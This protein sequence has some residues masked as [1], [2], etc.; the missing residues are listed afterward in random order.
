MK[1]LLTP[2]ALFVLLLSL[3]GPY[4]PLLKAQADARTF[5]ETGHTVSG[6]FLA[7]WQ[8]HGGLAQ[9]GYPLSEEFAE[10]SPLNGQSYTVQYFERAVFE[11]HPENQPPFNILLSQLG[12]FRY[13]AKYPTGA[14]G[15]QA[16]SQNAQHFTQTGHTLGGVFRS[17]W[18]AHGGLAQQGF[19]ISDEFQEQSDLNGQSY[20]VQYF[21]R[22]V[23]EYHPE[24]AG[25]PYEV[26]LSQLGKYQLDSRSN[27]SNLDDDVDHWKVPYCEFNSH[28]IP[29]S[30]PNAPRYAAPAL[31]S[32]PTLD[33][34]AL[35]LELQPHNGT[36]N[37]RNSMY[38][39]KLS[40]RPEAAN[41]I[42]FTLDLQFL[43]RPTTP[44]NNENWNGHPAPI[45][46]V[47]FAVTKWGVD[48]NWDWELQ[49]TNVRG[50][51]NLPSVWS[52]AGVNE[53]ISTDVVAEPVAD[54]WHH[55]VLNG[56]VSNGKTHYDS[57]AI[58]G[59]DHVLNSDKYDFP[60][61]P[62]GGQIVT[63]HVQL[64]QPSANQAGYQVFIDHLKVSWH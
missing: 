51:A 49:W 61:R 17:Y 43:Y 50:A 58:D 44:F 29:C 59:I 8:D 45:Q 16:N 10:V 52:V 18:E 24:N 48:R 33:G 7:Y 46:A 55:L 21:E 57:F 25:T 15:Q 6:Q 11:K 40:N 2:V 14:P 22:A 32:N 37:Y 19:P 23:F 4:P 3:S 34:Q 47:E 13:K 62:I 56:K 31:V 53:W 39:Y 54:Q 9:Q 5:P 27:A 38:Q 63:T 64:D 30:N 60:A 20:K 12:T 1:K 28:E 35:K 26:L 42:A 41:A 36:P